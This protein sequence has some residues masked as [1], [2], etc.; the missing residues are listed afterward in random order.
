MGE[1]WGRILKM[2]KGFMNKKSLVIGFILGLVFASVISI[3][4]VQLA[5]NEVKKG[6][7]FFIAGKSAEAAKSF[8]KA[9]MFWPPLYFDT[10]VNSFKELSSNIDTKVSIYI[11]LKTPESDIQSLI[12]EI[13]NLPGVVD[14]KFISSDEGYKRYAKLKGKKFVEMIKPDP[15]LIP[16]SIEVEVKGREFKLEITKLARS[17]SFV[18]EVHNYKGF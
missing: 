2:K 17:K 14:V 9:Q 15:S 18:E 16:A 6:I 8:K 5:A 11:K 13:K 4:L 7:S 3:S 1:I 10:E 12:T